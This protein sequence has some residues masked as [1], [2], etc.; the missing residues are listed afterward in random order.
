MLAAMKHLRLLALASLLTLAPGCA[1]GSGLG[2]KGL[3]NGLAASV[4][5]CVDAAVDA[6][7]TVRAFEEIQA[8]DT[9]P[10]VEPVNPAEDGSTSGG[11]GEPE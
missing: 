2:W 6:A 3:L 8:A 9:E 11:E 7:A 1:T 4:S 10:P 5:R